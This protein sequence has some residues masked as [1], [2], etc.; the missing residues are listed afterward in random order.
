MATFILTAK[1]DITRGNTHINKGE[2]LTISIAKLGISPFN[3]FSRQEYLP[4]LRQQFERNGVFLKNDIEV[5]NL[6]GSFDIKKV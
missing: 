5:K 2:V 3:L 4:M 6:F 1:N